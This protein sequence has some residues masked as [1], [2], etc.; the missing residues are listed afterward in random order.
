MRIDEANCSHSLNVVCKPVVVASE[1]ETDENAMEL[2]G[3]LVRSDVD[4][5][6]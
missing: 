4:V 6:D 3:E 2:L 1:E 5:I